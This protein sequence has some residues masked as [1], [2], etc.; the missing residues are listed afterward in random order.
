MFGKRTASGE[1]QREKRERKKEREIE[2]VRE[3]GEHVRAGVSIR[4][5]M[6]VEKERGGVS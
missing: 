4:L 1:R 5:C 2:S 6:Q 3:R